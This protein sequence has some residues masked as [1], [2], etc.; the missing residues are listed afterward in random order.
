VRN[1][2]CQFCDV[3]LKKNPNA[4]TKNHKCYKNYETGPDSCGMEPEI[5][6]EGAKYL[7]D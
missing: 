7:E 5:I 2:F 1:K 6:I 4:D 3:V